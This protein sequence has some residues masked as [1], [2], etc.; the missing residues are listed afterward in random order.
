MPIAQQAYGEHYHNNSLNLSNKQS[1]CFY[2]WDLLFVSIV[3]LGGL[4]LTFMA[5]LILILNFLHKI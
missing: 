5:L 2:Y 1:Y 3:V 4:I